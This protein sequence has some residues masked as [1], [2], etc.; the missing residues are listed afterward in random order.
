MTKKKIRG[1]Y[2]YMIEETRKGHLLGLSKGNPP[3]T[4]SKAKLLLNE[5]ND[6]VKDLNENDDYPYMVDEVNVSDSYNPDL[7]I[8]NDIDVSLKFKKRVE[9]AEFEKKSEDRIDLAFKNGR[10]FPT[11]IEQIYW[12]EREVMLFLN[13]RKK[14]L[15]L[16]FVNILSGKEKIFRMY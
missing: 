5:L 11:Y 6:R 4:S 16:H 12:P 7:P 14:G 10:R 1:S 3:I 8:L 2:F 15:N 9:G 13:T